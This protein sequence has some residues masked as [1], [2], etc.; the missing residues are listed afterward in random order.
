MWESTVRDWENGTHWPTD[1]MHRR[2][3][4]FLN[5][6]PAGSHSLYHPEDMT[7]PNGPL[8]AAAQVTNPGAAIQCENVAV[9]STIRTAESLEYSPPAKYNRLLPGL[10]IRFPM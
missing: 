6:K 4:E 10:Q 3:S 5:L 8:S 7:F 9:T 2:L 1:T